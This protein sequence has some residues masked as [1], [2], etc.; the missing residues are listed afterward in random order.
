MGADNLLD[1]NGLLRQASK[2]K[3][4]IVLA[5]AVLVLAASTCYFYILSNDRAA[6][7]SQKG[8][9]YDALSARLY[10]LSRDHAALVA[11]SQNLSERYDNLS[12][13]YDDLCTNASSVMSDYEKLSGMVGRFQE[14]SGAV[15][16]LTY[17]VR[18]AD[19]PDGPRVFVDATVYNVGNSKADSFT[20]KCKIIFDN[21]PNV[22]EHVVNGL[23]PLDKKTI[24]WNYSAFTDIDAL[25][26]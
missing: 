13:R 10:N 4:I 15:L 22:D 17:K 8:A 16:A 26:I 9:E 18:R 20:I 23:E 24:T 5:F 7:L 2:Y 3:L 19:T 14:K 11:S 1:V 6:A 21:Q 12:Y 25:W